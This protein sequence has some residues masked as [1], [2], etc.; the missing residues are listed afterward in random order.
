MQRL[1]ATRRIL[2]C[3]S[4]CIFGPQSNPNPAGPSICRYASGIVFFPRNYASVAQSLTQ[5]LSCVSLLAFKTGLAHWD[6]NGRF[7]G[8]LWDQSTGICLGKTSGIQYRYYGSLATK[9]QR[10]PSFSALN[11]DD[12]NYF[13]SILGEKNVIQDEDKLLSANT[14]WLRKY[15]GSSQL[16]LLP[17]S[18]EEVPFSLSGTSM[19]I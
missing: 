6:W 5:I 8:S 10:N 4:K 13:K 14:D 19:L 3:S 9:I 16:L 7:S 17:R 12:V 1:R 2:S 18:T 11:F 15:K